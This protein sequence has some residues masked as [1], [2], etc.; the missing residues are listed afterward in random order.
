MHK[1]NGLMQILQRRNR[2]ETFSKQISCFVKFII[3]TN[4][5]KSIKKAQNYFFLLYLTKTK[6]ILT[7]SNENYHKIHYVY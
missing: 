7:F 4:E 2:G 3:V 1:P 5:K 6:N